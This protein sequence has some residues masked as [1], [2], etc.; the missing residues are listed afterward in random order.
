MRWGASI[1]GAAEEAVLLLTDA[2]WR[3]TF[4]SDET[5]VGRTV[6]LD[7]RAVRILGVLPPEEEAIRVGRAIDA[8]APMDAPLPW[9]GRATGFLTVLGRVRPKLTC[10]L[11]RTLAASKPLRQ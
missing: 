4:G 11:L 3:T 10:S 2:F 6:E 1:P 9:M 7:G 8:W 5:V